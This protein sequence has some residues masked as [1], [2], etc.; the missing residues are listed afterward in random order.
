MEKLTPKK[1]WL[2]FGI[3]MFIF[4]VVGIRIS[5]SL[6]AIKNILSSGVVIRHLEAGP[7][8]KE[9]SKY[10]DEYFFKQQAKMKLHYY[11]TIS[12]YAHVSQSDSKQ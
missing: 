1:V 11:P 7:W 10:R 12:S 6:I 8:E 3:F 2:M 4:V 5:H 9:A